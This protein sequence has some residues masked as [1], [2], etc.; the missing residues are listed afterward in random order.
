MLVPLRKYE[1]QGWRD[2]ITITVL[3]V[4]TADPSSVPSS[5]IH[6]SLLLPQNPIPFLGLH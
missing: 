1:L 6:G 5:Y 4:L 3:P 2:G